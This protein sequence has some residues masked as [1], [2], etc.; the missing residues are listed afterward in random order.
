VFIPDDFVFSIILMVQFTLMYSKS[1]T[2]GNHDQTAVSCLLIATLSNALEWCGWS[3]RSLEIT[4]M[5]MDGCF[6][7]YMHSIALV[8]CVSFPRQLCV[9]LV[10]LFLRSHSECLPFLK[11]SLSINV[12]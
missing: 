10:I 7:S 5:L 11:M 12:E 2:N 1:I 9:A 3:L 4:S 6:I 8:I